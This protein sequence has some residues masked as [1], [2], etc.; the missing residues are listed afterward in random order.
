ML[1]VLDTPAIAYVVSEAFESGVE[2]VA[3]IVSGLATRP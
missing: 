1:P 2:E 3:L